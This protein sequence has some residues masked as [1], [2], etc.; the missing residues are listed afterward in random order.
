MCLMNPT[1]RPKTNLKRF[2]SII[3]LLVLSTLPSGERC[4]AQEAVAEEKGHLLFRQICSGCHGENAKGGRGPDLTTGDLKHGGTDLDVIKNIR[5]GIAG[6][7]MPSFPMSEDDAALIVAFLRSVQKRATGE[8]STGDPQSGQRLFWGAG[9]CSGC[10]MV[11]GR[12]GR[13]GP[14]LSHIGKERKIVEL[15]QAITQPSQTL[16]ASFE[17]A[18]LEFPDGRTLRG[19]ARNDDTFSIQLMDRHEKLHLLRKRDLKQVA[20]LRESLMPIPKLTASEVEDLLAFLATAS[21]EESVAL[22]PRSEW[23]PAPDFNVSFQRLRYSH[24]ESQNWLTYWGHYEGTHYSDLDAVTPANAST[25]RSQW[26]FQYGGSNIESTPLVVDGLM[27]VTGPLNTVTA[28]DARTGRT[29]WTYRRSLPDGKWRRCTVMTNR[30]LSVLGDRLY[31]ATLDAHLVAL[32]AKTGN[33]IWDVAVEDHEQGFSITAAP[34]ALDGRIIVGVTLAECALTGF[35]DAFDATTGQRIWRFWAIPQVGDPARATWAGDSATFG[36]SPTW[37]TGTYD[38]ETD[39]VF[40]TTGNPL[41]TYDGTVRAGD[42]LY[43]C[44]VLALDAKNGKLKW[45]FQFTPHDTHDW[46]ANQAAILINAKFRGE[47]RKLLIQ[48]NRN[49]FY[50]VLDRLTGKFLFGKPFANQTWATG[51]DADGRPIVKSGT[52][53][54]PEGN[55]VCPDAS[56]NTNW[57]APSFDHQ[58][59]L[60]Y[61]AARD[62][63]GSY[64]RETRAPR[65]GERYTGGDPYLDPEIGSPGAIRAIDALTG[66]IRWNFRL[67]TGSWAAGVLGTA[68]GVVFASSDDGYLIALEARTGKELWHYQTGA[69]I[70]SSP[71]SYSIDGRQ[72]IAVSTSSSLIAF[73]LP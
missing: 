15:R 59:N 1:N 68:G 12:G 67:K 65:K 56:G 37:M 73:G 44:S 2:H 27:F 50:Y 52:D 18:E 26:A 32:D 9:Q 64:R 53:P 31:L 28:L 71:I 20:Y 49:G 55:Y 61:V 8:R 54:T 21:D 33:V 45:Y 47:M 25:L 63:C 10:H 69:R 58:T 38:D 57:A 14:D 39:T 16:R 35:V 51:L 34:L 62:T 42:N 41:P 24:L 30:G 13:L 36:G 40:W 17:T 60:L 6:T 72:Q 3:F 11:G 7:P 48:A 29:I 5:E 22:V 19:V 4:Q 23:T 70:Q 43:T 66:E 46:D